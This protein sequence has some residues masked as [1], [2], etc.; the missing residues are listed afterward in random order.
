MRELFFPRAGKPLV[1]RFSKHFVR[2]GTGGCAAAA[3][4]GVVGVSPIIQGALGCL[5]G[6]LFAWTMRNTQMP[7]EAIGAGMERR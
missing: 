2:F 4:S 6:I 3:M 5:A 1:W 7:V